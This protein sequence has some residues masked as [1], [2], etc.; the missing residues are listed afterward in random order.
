MKGVKCQ[1]LRSHKYHTTA[2]FELTISGGFKVK[3]KTFYFFISSLFI[4][5]GSKTTN[6]QFLAVVYWVEDR[7]NFNLITG[8]AAKGIV[9]AGKK[10]KKNDAYSS[11]AAA[12]K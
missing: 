3:N 6:G 1:P 10:L 7:N 2:L 5:Q 4:G 11:L 9:I 12:V 8:S